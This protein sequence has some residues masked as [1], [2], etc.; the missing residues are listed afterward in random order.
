MRADFPPG[1]GTTPSEDHVKAL[2]SNTLLG[3]TVPLY[4]TP[5]T[6]SLS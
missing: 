5:F 1:A 4:L 2:P 3:P 6:V